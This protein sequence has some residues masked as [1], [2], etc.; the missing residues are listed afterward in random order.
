V[1]TIQPN[2][3]SPEHEYDAPGLLINGKKLPP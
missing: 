3:N 1:N 2:K